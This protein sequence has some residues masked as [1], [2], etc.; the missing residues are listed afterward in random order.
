MQKNIYKKETIET[1]D[2]FVT[3][4]DIER[5]CNFMKERIESGQFTI[6]IQVKSGHNK[7]CT[8]YNE[9]EKIAKSLLSNKEIITEITISNIIR[10]CHSKKLIW[11]NIP[12]QEEGGFW[13]KKPGL[14]ISGQDTDG[15]YG[16]WIEATFNKGERLMDSF[17]TNEEVLKEYLNKKNIKSILDLNESLK[18]KILNNSKESKKGTM[19]INTNNIN[20][21]VQI[22]GK[23]NSQEITNEKMAEPKWY[24]KIGIRIITGVIIGIILFL[25]GIK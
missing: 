7:S 6:K 24:Q 21:N 19:I 22:G 25:L 1:S 23:G 18:N 16:D 15:S 3:K 8:N 17:T 12:F 9:F 11:L 10:T 4:V 20:N 2:W 13:P 14:N 5:I